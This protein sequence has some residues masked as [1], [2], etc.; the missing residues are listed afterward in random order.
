[1]WPTNE[2]QATVGSKDRKAPGQT[3]EP[4][5]SHR[6]VGTHSSFSRKSLDSV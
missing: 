4:L 2:N 5:K 3:F 1:M 6:K